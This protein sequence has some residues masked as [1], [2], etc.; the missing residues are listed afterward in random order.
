[1]TFWTTGRECQHSRNCDASERHDSRKKG[2]G[3]KNPWLLRQLS[4]LHQQVLWSL[5]TTTETSV[6]KE[7]EL[8]RCSKLIKA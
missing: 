1:M 4:R 2:C 8:S 5:Q 7:T 6:L 3:E